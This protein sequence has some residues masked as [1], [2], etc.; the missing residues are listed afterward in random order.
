MIGSASLFLAIA[1]GAGGLAAWK[2]A[3]LHAAQEAAAAQ[4]EPMEAVAAALAVAHEYVRTSTAIGT[5]H[6]LRSVTLR[7][8]LAGTVHEVFLAPG[9]IV[10]AGTLLVGLDVAVEQAEL[11]ALE[12]QAAL[13]ESMLGRVQRA[14]ENRGAS[15]SDVDRAAAER[16]VAK[17]NVAR[18]QAVIERKTLRA[19]FRARLGLSDV[20]V[21]QYLTEGSE[22]TTLQGIDD[23]VHVDFAVAQGVAAGLREGQAIE[24]ASNG[25]SALLPAT[26]IAIDARIDS[27]TRNAWIRAPV[28]DSNGALVPG[29]SVR[30]QVPV[31][32]P[33]QAVVVP[34]SAL[35]RGPDGD[36][37]FT[38]HEDAQGVI[39]AQLRMVSSGAILGDL[40]L[41]DA[42]LEAGEQIAASGS[43]KLREGVRVMIAPDASEQ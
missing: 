35:L 19:P 40:V 15:E 31:G 2:R 16:D 5:V 36:H 4:P 43:F 13:A 10:E 24:V 29:A 37:V 26:I 42:G 6:A 39:R 17:A 27:A 7:N 33:R 9:S 23:S 41:I 22:L 1:L 11:A 8:E 12:A 21:G 32:V 18:A 25:R 14:L 34:V 28:D 20:H 30:V 3:E 38:L